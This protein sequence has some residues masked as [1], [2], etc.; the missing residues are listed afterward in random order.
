MFVLDMYFILL[1]WCLK[2]GQKQGLK[3]GTA[4]RMLRAMMTLAKTPANQRK[5]AQLRRALGELLADVLRRDFFG[6]AG[7]ELVIQD[8][9]IQSIRRKVERV[10]R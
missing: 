9:T 10:E 4:R 3:I 1:N 8:G 6:T 7:V 2:G 5:M